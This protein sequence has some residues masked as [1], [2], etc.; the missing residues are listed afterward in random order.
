MYVSMAPGTNTCSFPMCDA[1]WAIETATNKV[2]AVIDLSFCGKAVDGWPSANGGCGGIGVLA[3]RPKEGELYA[4][5]GGANQIAVIDQQTNRVRKIDAGS[6]PGL[7]FAPDGKHFYEISTYNLGLSVFDIA[8][9]ARPK[10]YKLLS[11]CLDPETL[12]VAPGSSRIYVVCVSSHTLSVIEAADPGG[13]LKSVHLPF[14]PSGT[15]AFSKTGDF[16]Y[17]IGGG[18]QAVLLKIDTSRYTFTPLALPQ[19]GA[20][21]I[22]IGTKIY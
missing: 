8:D 13:L 18:D 12:A 19:G 7:A 6:G 2:V 3:V 15:L 16:V 17:A 5:V 10:H 11:P 20:N 4:P 22:V 21:G 9:T 1:V 14:Q